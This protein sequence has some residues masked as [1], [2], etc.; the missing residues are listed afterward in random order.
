MG[1]VVAIGKFEGVHLG[2]QTILDRLCAEADERDAI[3][4]VYTFTEN[5]LSLIAP[6]RCPKPL[7]TPEHRATTLLSRGIDEVI[8]V[9]FTEEFASL[10]PEAFVKQ[11]L[12]DETRVQHVIVGGDFR[13]GENAVGTPETLAALGETYGFT[14]E[15]IE[16]VTDAEHGR[17][18]S[19]QI[20]EALD[21]GD[22]ELAARLLGTPHQVRG[23]VVHGDARGRELGFPTA[24]LGPREGSTHIDGF[25]PADGVYGGI[26]HVGDEEYLAA[27]S[28]GNNPTFT[29]EGESRVE[30][31]LLDF[32]GDLYGEDIVIEFVHHVRP[33]LTFDGIEPLLEAMRDDVEQVRARHSA[34]QTR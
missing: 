9:D 33:T 21:D 7:M 4:V 28:V 27:I 17:I 12:V 6:E 3:A 24:N 20:R 18:S 29:P 34:P 23:V 25:I 2:H 26:A 19:S 15:V 11:E 5:P 8:M 16:E 13:F 31:F 10:S 1:A 32:T 30:A 22:V 14:V